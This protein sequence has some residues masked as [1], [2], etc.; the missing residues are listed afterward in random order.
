M[1]VA[2][3]RDYTRFFIAEVCRQQTQSVANEFDIEF[4]DANSLEEWQ[5][6]APFMRG[7]EYLNEQTLAHVWNELVAALQFT[8]K[9]SKKNLQEYLQQANGQWHLVGRICFHLAENKNNDQYPFAFLVTYTK[10]LSSKSTLQHVPLQR[11][12]E[13]FSGQ[14]N[15]K[16]LLALLTPIQQAAEK[17]PF[18]KTLVDTGEIYQPQLWSIKEAHQF[19]SEIPLFEEAGVI[20]RVPNWWNSKKPPRPKVS[21][22]IGQAQSTL[23][24]DS[25]LDFD[26]AL[27]L[28]NDL[29]LN[30]KEWQKLLESKESLVKIKGQWVEINPDKLKQVLSH[31]NNIRKTVRKNGLS[32][33]EGMRMLAGFEQAEKKSTADK[34][35]PEWS[36]LIA[37]DWLK[38]TLQTLQEPSE[39]YHKKLQHILDQKLHATLRSYQQAGVHWL[40]L[41]YSLKLGGCLADDM[42][43][44][45]TIQLLS[46]LL[47]IKYQNKKTSPHLLIVPASLIGNW[48]S[49]AQRF[50]PGLNILVAHSSM[51]KTKQL[52]Q[53]TAEQ[54]ANYDVV[55]TTYA[56]LSRLPVLHELSWDVVVLDEAQQIKNPGSK[57]TRAVKNLKSRVRFS[58]TGT[59]I[60][61]RLGDL[62]SL[63]DFTLPGLLGS[64]QSFSQYGKKFTEERSHFFSAVRKLVKPYILRRLKT[65]KTIITD[66]PD[67]TEVDAFCYL[68][69]EQAALYQQ[70]V[71]ELERQL[72]IVDDGMKRRG[73][74]LTYLMRFKQICNHPSQLTGHGAFEEAHSGKFQRLREIAETI[75]DKQEKVLVFTQFTEIIPAIH[76]MLMKIFGQPGLCLD[77]STAIKKRTQFVQDFTKKDGPP[78]FVL[79]LKAGGTGLNLTSASHVIH[80]DR[81]WNP[82]VEN[83]AT[84]R[85]YRI[86]QKKNVLVHKFI[87]SGTIEEKIDT[88]IRSKKSLSD[89]ILSQ[90]SEV[91]LS[92]LRN[93]ELIR[94]VSLDIHKALGDNA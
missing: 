6:R 42:G 54:I 10:Q 46:L 39:Q 9:L 7:A 94:L 24:L 34:E 1:S 81:W 33:S 60:E 78:F 27:S 29:Q 52:S 5:A 73:L 92:E 25:M 76:A 69:K 80:F 87:C 58:L 8:L 40:W 4:P 21:V 74:V 82:A 68:S 65:D 83:Q 28:P 19:L 64:H 15:K 62:W 84:D 59:P 13:E 66:L 48:Q 22:S 61:N 11:A 23:G 26:V 72:N 44:G 31:W 43:L 20:V 67:K 18:I 49:E 85:A 17:S 77:G 89:E 47:L 71:Q 53:L 36:E 88:L 37:G 86:G 14:K 75:A 41:L 12:L 16:A 35:V 45:K 51:D 50:S 79:S 93:E 38:K 91:V 57:Q 3:W 30:E 90:E 56:Y 63:F 55:I 2:Y 70:S 32:F